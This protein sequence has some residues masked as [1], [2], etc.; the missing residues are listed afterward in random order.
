MAALLDSAGMGPQV[1]NVRRI[2]HGFVL[3]FNVTVNHSQ[4]GKGEK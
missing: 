4:M 1:G 2:H 3:F